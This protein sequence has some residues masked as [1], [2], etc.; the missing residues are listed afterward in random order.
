MRSPVHHP[1]V[2]V[3]PCATGLLDVDVNVVVEAGHL[4]LRHR[5]VTVQD[6]NKVYSVNPVA[7]E[8]VRGQIEAALNDIGADAIKIGMLGD[9]ALAVAEV[10][11]A[12]PLIP[13]VLDPVMLAK[14]GTALTDGLE[15]LKSRLASRAAGRPPTLRA[16][17]SASR[18]PF[19]M[20][21]TAWSA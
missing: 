11:E 12:W 3:K 19:S 17:R 9:A 1:V 20:Q 7:P 4:D 8:I 2:D 18:C 10:L 14:D 6:T 16:R 15:P 21:R 13:V 5:A